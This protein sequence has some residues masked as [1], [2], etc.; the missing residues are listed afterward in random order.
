[1]LPKKRTKVSKKREIP[2]P[3]VPEIVASTRTPVNYDWSQHS[4]RPPFAF[5]RDDMVA[6]DPTKPRRLERFSIR[7]INELNK[8]EYIIEQK[9]NAI[10]KHSLIKTD[11]KG[12]VLTNP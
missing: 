5:R 3:P 1:M 7:V 6:N 8:D 9:L 2:P 4:L 12:M 11:S 10:L